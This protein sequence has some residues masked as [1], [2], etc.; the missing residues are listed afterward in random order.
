[1]VV[2][3]ARFSRP[4]LRIVSRVNDM[5]W[6]GRLQ[7]A[8]ADDLV[9]VY[10]SAGR[11]LATSA[12]TPGVLGVLSATGDA[13]TEELVVTAGSPVIGRSISDLMSDHPTVV[14]L[15]IQRDNSVARWHEITG[16]SSPGDVVIA[17]GPLAGLQ[18]LTEALAAN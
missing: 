9:S 6:C 12:V 3:S 16:A 7:R 14:I 15:G 11:H 5:E 4:D 13:I 2:T 10:A 8:G 17:R 18:S 1:M